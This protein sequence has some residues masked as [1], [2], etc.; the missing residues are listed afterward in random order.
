MTIAV[1]NRRL[2]GELESVGR[3]IAQRG[4]RSVITL[5]I[6]VTVVFIVLRLS[7]DPALTMLGPDASQPALDAFRLKHGLDASLLEQYAL[8]MRNLLT[9][10]L[11]ISMQYDRPVSEL[12]MQRVPA[13][14]ELGF[15]ALLIAVVA[16]VPMGL[17]AAL[18]QNSIVDRASMFLAFIGQS[19]PGFFIGIMLILVLSLRLN[20]LPS[21]GRGEASQLV[22]PAI[23]L[24]TGLLAALARMTRSS[25]LEVA[26]A[27]YVRTARAKGLRTSRVITH[28][29]LRTAAL[30][31]VTMLGMWIS[32]IIGGAAVTETV[33][34]WPG[35]GRLIVDAVSSRDYPVVQ[36][37]VLLIAGTVIIVN[38][39]VDVAYGWLDPRISA[40]RG[41]T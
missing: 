34:A 3:F 24:A 22:M 15:W 18:R 39:L 40:T 5:W 12:F 35:V 36:S 27:D 4:I 2:G 17:L 25:V 23:T 8:F 7:G 26:N 41:T 32:A 21:S 16:G 28:H 11:G 6:V 31:I 20:L 14:L 10:D 30:P 38:L 9:G 29:M 37:L 19:A 1:T 33:F 13:T